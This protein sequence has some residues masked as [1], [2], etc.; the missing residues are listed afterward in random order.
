MWGVFSFTSFGFG[1]FLRVLTYIINEEKRTQKLHLS[2]SLTEPDEYNFWKTNT[3]SDFQVFRCSGLQVFRCSGVQVFRSSGLQ[4]FRSS[5]L[6]VFRSSGPQT[7]IVNT[8][9][10]S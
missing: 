9:E 1:F 8:I 4:V 6:Q 3:T 7:L 2:C 5:G 10:A